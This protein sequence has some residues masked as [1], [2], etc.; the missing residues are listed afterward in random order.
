MEYQ[1]NHYEQ[2]VI[3]LALELEHYASNE[4]SGVWVDARAGDIG[5]TDRWNAIFRL[6]EKD[7]NSDKMKEECMVRSI[8]ICGEIAKAELNRTVRLFIRPKL[9]QEPIGSFFSFSAEHL[10]H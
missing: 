2:I 9:M 8:E 4:P 7:D 3:T 10:L 6:P 1:R 5:D